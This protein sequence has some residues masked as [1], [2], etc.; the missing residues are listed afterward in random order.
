M[1]SGTLM[2]RSPAWHPAR[3]AGAVP[4]VRA[5]DRAAAGPAVRPTTAMAAAIARRNPGDYGALR[6][7]A[8]CGNWKCL[9]RAFTVRDRP[10]AV[11]CGGK[12]TPRV[13]AAQVSVWLAEDQEP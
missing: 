9:G 2:P 13:R 6:D 10:I 8:V 11:L 1:A 4:P 12:H 7:L 5:V 3:A